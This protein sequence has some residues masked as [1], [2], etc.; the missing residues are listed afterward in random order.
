MGFVVVS[1][2]SIVRNVRGGIGLEGWEREGVLH[3]DRSRLPFPRA[4]SAS[5]ENG[6]PVNLVLHLQRACP[7]KKAYLPA[8]YLWPKDAAYCFLREISGS[9]LLY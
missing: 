1:L 5:E 3:M 9:F 2:D 7:W 8:F 6:G 4:A